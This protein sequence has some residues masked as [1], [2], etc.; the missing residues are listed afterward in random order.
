M[1]NRATRSSPAWELWERLVGRERY[2]VEPDGSG[3]VVAG[4][5]LAR[6][7]PHL[8]P[9]YDKRIKQLFRRPRTDHSFWADLAAAL[10]ADN[11]A[12]RKQLVRLRGEAGIGD[13]IGVLRVFGVIAWMHQ[14][15]EGQQPSG[16]GPGGAAG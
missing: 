8:V 1:P 9:V 10:R 12:L 14:S 6:K 3:P 5:L 7:R 16:S 4:K 2:L 11:G 15:G 13:D